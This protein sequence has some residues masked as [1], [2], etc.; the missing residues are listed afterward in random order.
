[1]NHEYRFA[2]LNGRSRAWLELE[3]FDADREMEEEEGL[4]FDS[5]WEGWD[6]FVAREEAMSRMADLMHD[7]ARSSP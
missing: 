1:M 5:D 4:P 6:S 3:E 2:S 7:S